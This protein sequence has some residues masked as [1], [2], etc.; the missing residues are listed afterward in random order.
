[1]KVR[2]CYSNVYFNSCFHWVALT[3]TNNVTFSSFPTT[4]QGKIIVSVKWRLK[5]IC[6]YCS[7]Q[8]PIHGGNEN[9]AMKSWKS[10]KTK[11]AI[12][13]LYWQCKQK[14][15]IKWMLQE[16]KNFQSI[17]LNFESFHVAELQTFFLGICD[18]MIL[19]M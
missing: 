4:C 12:S 3:D 17:Q 11:L 9:Y 10:I 5:D 7:S 8:M 18:L 16:K 13:W 14:L 2:L 1:M 6:P 19:K 15:I